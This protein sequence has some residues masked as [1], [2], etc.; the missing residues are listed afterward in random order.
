MTLPG[1][2]VLA[3]EEHEALL[4][5][6][7]LAPVG[8]VQADR[9]GDIVLLNPVSAQ[10]LLPL[11]ERA[12]LVN[13]FDALAEVA[14]GLRQQVADFPK[15]AGVVC[16]NLRLALAGSD[17]D[18]AHPCVL[19]V[20]IV[21]LDEQRLMVVL[22]DVTAS[23]RR[24]RALRER[25]AWF[26]AILTGIRDYALVHLDVDGNV[27]RWNE[28][29]GR[30]TG[31]TAEQV[32]GRPYTVWQ[33]AD[34]LTTY[35]VRDRL[36]EADANGWSLDEGWRLRA[37]GTRFWASALLAPLDGRAREELSVDGEAAPDERSYS[38]I[39]RDISDKREASEALHRATRCDQL[40]GLANRH[41]FFEAADLELARCRRE[42]RALSVA[43]FD[44]DDFKRLN[45][46]HGHPTGD[47]VLQHVARTLAAA[48]RAVDTVA[49]LG[50][51]EFVVLM[52]G[53]G[54]VDA[55][56]LAERCRK[57]V[58]ALEI[59]DAEGPVRVTLSGGVSQ[60]DPDGDDLD[61]LIRR[62]DRALY[63]AKAAGRNR[64]ETLEA[65]VAP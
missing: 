57:T 10:L 31:H 12:E 47:L 1:E 51:E 23:V 21:R 36:H 13:I 2:E 8:L 63:R 54:L 18:R 62:A 37:D 19:A 60:L 33:E 38:L 6:L 56:R 9:H 11:S 20:T 65:A 3:R 52:P 53:T 55:H 49:R 58:A 25:E 45:D 40:T 35:V 41:A 4:Q 43:I 64:I 24:E 27:A 26:N 44:A 14:P 17:G 15:P 34:A 48:F 29:I 5:F 22:Q 30:V 42:P 39:L 59:P 16:E 32:V 46:R 28:S 7:Y 61:A 50:G